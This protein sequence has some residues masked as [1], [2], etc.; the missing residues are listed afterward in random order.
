MAGIQETIRAALRSTPLLFRALRSGRAIIHFG[1]WR[2]AA[3]GMIRL[4]RPPRQDAM[5]PKLSAFRLDIALI[6]ETLRTEGVAPVGLLPPDELRCIRAI[7][8]ELP[9]GEFGE[10]D[11]VP[12][13]RTLTE[14]AASVARRYLMAE[15]ELL[16][17]SLFVA[18]AE[19]PSSPI[20]YDSDRR[21]HF[22]DAGW[23][24][25]SLFLYLTDVSEDSGARQVVI[26][27]HRALTVWDALRGSF[28]ESE[29]QARY[30]RRIR[31][32][33]GPAGTMF[34]EDTAAIHRRQLHTRRH[35]ILHILFVSRR[36]WASKGRSIRRY[37]DYLRA[38][39]AKAQDS[40]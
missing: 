28:S 8:N 27:T 7:T 1:P 26:G 29:I 15:P 2:H 20:A 19:N 13:V 14:A 10:F 24:S 30:P 11:E 33:T 39:Q 38:H 22:E 37:S 34:F 17:C 12:E 32:I 9:P 6:L 3:R 36:S 18:Q 4:L 23:H 21:F 40:S 25:L 35:V 16:E 5:P 31:T